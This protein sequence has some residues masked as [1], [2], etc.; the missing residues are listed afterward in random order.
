MASGVQRRHALQCLLD[1]TQDTAFL[2]SLPLQRHAL[3][4]SHQIQ[5][6]GVRPRPQQTNISIMIIIL[7]TVMLLPNNIVCNS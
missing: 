4:R 1:T 2:V 6:L 5:T 7:Q 3:N